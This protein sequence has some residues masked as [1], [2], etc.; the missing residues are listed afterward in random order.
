MFIVRATMLKSKWIKIFSI[1][2]VPLQ[3]CTLP[4]TASEC[5]E[6]WPMFHQNLNRTGSSTSV[7]VANLT[8]PLWNYSTGGSIYSSPAIVDNRVYV[9]SKDGYLYCL[10]ASTGQKIWRHPTGSEVNS[11]PTISGGRA[12]FGSDDG[13]FY[14]LDAETGDPYWIKWIGWNQ[15]WA[16]RSNPIVEEEYVYVG[17]GDHDIYCFNTSSGS[18]IWRY[19]TTR[20]V[21]SSPALSNG[22]LYLAVGDFYV[23]ALNAS[24]GNELW[25]TPTGTDMSSPCVHGNYLY[26]GSY[27]GDVLC[28]DT[29]TG[30]ISWRYQTGN[31]VLSSPAYAYGHVYV[32]S[33]DNSIYCLDA[34]TGELIWQKRT[35][36]WVCSSPAIADGNLYVGS[37]DYGIY[38]LNASTGEVKWR[39]E[40]G[41]IV[42]SSPAIS[43]GT[44]YIGSHDNCI[45]SFSLGAQINEALSATPESFVWSTLVFNIVFCVIVASILFAVF[46]YIKSLYHKQKVIHKYGSEPKKAW[47]H[48][49]IEA[50]CLLVIII[51]SLTLFLNLGDEYLWVADEQVYSQ[52]AYHMFKTGDY[53]TPST[54]G[55]LGIW[56]G[57]PPLLM[58]LITISYQ[59]FGV[60]NF[61]TR[62]FIPFFSVLS[63]VFVF[64][65]GKKLYNQTVGFLSAI[66]LGTFT[67]FYSFSRHAMIDIPLVCFIVA[68]LYFFILGTEE[69]GNIKY[70]LLSGVCFGLAFLTKQTGAL[71]IPLII[72]VYLLLTRRK[73]NFLLTKQFLLLLGTSFL[74][75]KPWLIYMTARFGIDF[76]NCYFFYSAI[77]RAVTPLE[78]HSESYLY[79]FN[80]LATNENLLW[81]VMLPF[82]VGLTVY[83]AFKHSKADILVISWISIVMLVFFFAQTK[84][85]YYIL[86]VYPAFALTIASMI[87]QIANRIKK[88][89]NF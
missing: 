2:F 30:T 52:M 87:Y 28:I 83:F 21:M 6:D 37:Q 8:A 76:W 3:L 50:I 16:T 7:T 25:H 55:E 85:Y 32:G 31:T 49:H 75:I 42:D 41:N 78:E 24:T 17:S 58:W 14:C 62:F 74:I 15:L 61:A 22:A 45:Y 89:I 65:L 64:Y 63:L 79:Y 70:S 53:L 67:T 44:L 38:C 80:Y 18:V 10:N 23:Y 26:I 19:V 86:P 54:Y 66:V 29:K 56:T 69:K 36:Y 40:T 11:S 72:I 39:Y 43:N 48:R 35:G 57:K 20:P 4:L 12:Y 81:V 51:F 13:W 34:S 84:I 47:F 33:Q 1:L 88:K 71:L 77:S 82:A 68:S 27:Q 9:G 60:T 5:S 73:I 46:R 59:L